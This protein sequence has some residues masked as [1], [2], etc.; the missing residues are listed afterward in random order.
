MKKNK[1]NQMN[2][3]RVQQ[4]MEGMSGRQVLGMQREALEA[5]FGKEEGSRLDSQI[6]LSR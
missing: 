6:I 3:I 2:I 4:Q 1:T 5:A